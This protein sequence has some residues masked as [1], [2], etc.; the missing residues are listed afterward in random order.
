MADGE[1][2][3][4]SRA[5]GLM[6]GQIRA[7]EEDVRTLTTDVSDH[8]RPNLHDIKNM[9]SGIQPT[10]AGALERINAAERDIGIAMTTAQTAK[11]I[12]EDAKRHNQRSA[13]MVPGAAGGGVASGGFLVW[14]WEMIQPWLRKVGL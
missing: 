6:E 3:Q 8:I 5:I 10:L 1:L 11:K 7:I 2:H 12:A 13:W 9:L 4:I 14:A